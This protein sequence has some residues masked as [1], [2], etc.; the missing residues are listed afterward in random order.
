MEAVDVKGLGKIYLPIGLYNNS[1]IPTIT[2]SPTPTTFPKC[3]PRWHVTSLKTITKYGPMGPVPS[4][5]SVTCPRFEIPPGLDIAL[6]LQVLQTRLQKGVGEN[7]HPFS[8]H[9]KSPR[10]F[11]A[12]RQQWRICQINM[13]AAG[14]DENPNFWNF[15]STYAGLIPLIIFF[16]IRNSLPTLFWPFEVTWTLTYGLHFTAQLRSSV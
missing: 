9:E 3:I 15:R 2:A 16:C 14:H 6:Y 10:C 5:L 1:S 8:G 12:S 13:A 11:P 7:S 4:R